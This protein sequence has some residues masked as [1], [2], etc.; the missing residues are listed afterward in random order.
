MGYENGTANET[1]E[2]SKENLLR[3][4]VGSLSMTVRLQDNTSKR[5]DSH[6]RLIATNVSAGVPD[7]SKFVVDKPWGNCTEGPPL[8]YENLAFFMTNEL[9]P[10]MVLEPLVMKPEIET[11]TESIIM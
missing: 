4:V 5:L 1:I 2:L 10:K 11:Q 8:S 9:L 3:K 6:H 7:S